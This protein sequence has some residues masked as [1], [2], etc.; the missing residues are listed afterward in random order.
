MNL[1]ATIHNFNEVP[2][3]LGTISKW[4]QLFRKSCN[5]GNYSKSALHIVKLEKTCCRKHVCC[6]RCLQSVHYCKNLFQ[7]CYKCQMS[8]Y[9]WLDTRRKQ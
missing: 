1:S 6:M 3:R 9:E 2:P 4:V 5:F 7:T 8:T